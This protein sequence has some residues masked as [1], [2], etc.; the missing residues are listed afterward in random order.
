MSAASSL[1]VAG[2]PA[3]FDAT[4][5][6]TATGAGAALGAGGSGEVAQA[7]Q[8]AAVNRA[9]ARIMSPRIAELARAREPLNPERARDAQPAFGRNSARQRAYHRKGALALVPGAEL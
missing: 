2:G 6:A 5:G 9:R 7:L 8:T 1:R 3:G 4:F